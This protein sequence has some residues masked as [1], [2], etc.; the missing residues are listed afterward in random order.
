[1][2]LDEAGLNLARGRRSKCHRAAVG[3][4]D[5]QG[6]TSLS[7]D[8]CSHYRA[9][10]GP[11]WWEGSDSRWLMT[12]VCEFPSLKHHQAMLC[13]PLQDADGPPCS[14]SL[15]PP[16]EF[17]WAWRERFHQTTP[18]AAKDAACEDV[19]ADTCRGWIRLDKTLHRLQCRGYLEYSVILTE[20]SVILTEYTVVL[21][22]Y[23]VILTFWR[24]VS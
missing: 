10:N 22:E 5:Q 20:Y 1:M 16:Q 14:P 11:W 8:P 21:T 15:N 17:C 6:G 12:K 3:V 23:S 19:P 18:L 2:Y 24:S 4:P 9:L 7:A 13:D